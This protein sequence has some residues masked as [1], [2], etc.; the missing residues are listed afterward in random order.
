MS[1]IVSVRTQLRD[2]AAVV[3]ACDRLGLPAPAEGTASFYSGEAKGLLV[4][5]P[6]WL[7]PVVLDTASGDVRFDNYEGAWGEPGQLDRFLQMY[8]VEKAKLEARRQG[9]TVSEQALED[10]SIMLSIQVG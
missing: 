4:Q 1:H 5:L 9:H 8:A 10:G 6:G 2:P 3:A 7:Y